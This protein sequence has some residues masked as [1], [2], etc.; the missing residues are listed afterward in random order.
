MDHCS[1]FLR[2]VLAVLIA[3]ACCSGSLA[4]NASSRSNVAAAK[5]A[6]GGIDQIMNAAIARGAIPGGV[7][8]VGHDGHVVYRKAF[9][10]RS[11]EPDKEAMTVDTIFDLASVTKCVATATSVMKLVQEGKVRLN[12]PVAAYLPD[13]ANNEKK[14]ITVRQLLTHFSGLRD[15]L[16]LETS[17]KGHNAA[18]EMV[19]NE[20]PIFSPGSRFYYSD[21][22]FEA[23]GFLVEKVSVMKL[24]QEGKV[25]LNDPVAAYLPDF[26]NNEKK[27]ITTQRFD[28]ADSKGIRQQAG[29]GLVLRAGTAVCCFNKTCTL[30]D[31]N[32]MTHE[33]QGGRATALLCRPAASRDHTP[34]GARLPLS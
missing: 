29:M 31:R 10:M 25:R 23:L 11:L 3:T 16:D 32:R 30:L 20:R 4:Q 9:G 7:V 17:W 24:V 2:L 26:A 18:Y 34:G 22:N 19:M 1:S 13:F 33:S 6:L 28:G 5:T 27:D 21:I 15:D 8:L 12:D 14:D